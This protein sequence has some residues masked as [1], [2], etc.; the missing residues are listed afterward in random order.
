[1]VLWLEEALM[2]S[3]LR[4]GHDDVAAPDP[5]PGLHGIATTSRSLRH[6]DTDGRRVSRPVGVLASPRRNMGI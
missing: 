5:R 3:F 6:P 4:D 2:T 1:M